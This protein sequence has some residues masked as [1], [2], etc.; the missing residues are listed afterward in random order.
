MSVSP[1]EPKS[2]KPYMT[3]REIAAHF[4]VSIK[5][6]KNWK[7]DG[8]LVYFQIGRVL[9]FDVAASAQALAEHQIL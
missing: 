8:L 6:V 9:R 3:T 5:T 2:T 1:E 7:R 4:G